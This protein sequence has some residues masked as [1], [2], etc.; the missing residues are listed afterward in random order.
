MPVFFSDLSSL[1][2]VALA[3]VITYAVV[4]VFL[5]AGGK[6]VLAKMN[7]FDLVV[8]VAVGSTVASVILSKDVSLAEGVVALGGLVLLQTVASWAS[9]RWLAFRDVLKSQ[10]RRLF[11][12]GAF[13]DDAIREERSNR[14]EV[15]QAMRAEGIASLDQVEAVVLETNGTFSVVRT[16]TGPNDTLTDV[17]E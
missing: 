3:C 8:T 12:Q 9:T 6:R 1:G 4:V 7:I 16:S 13:N 5:R 2:Q 14:N 17:V 11:Y 10:P 15:L